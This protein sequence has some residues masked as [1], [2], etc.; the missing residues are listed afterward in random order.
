DGAP[1][2]SR[3]GRTGVGAYAFPEPRAGA[4]RVIG[5]P[6]VGGPR[7]SAALFRDG[8]MVRTLLADA[9]GVEGVWW[10]GLDDL[11]QPAPAGGYELKSVAHDARLIDDGSVGDSGN[12]AGVFHTDSA[13]RAVPLP[14]G[15]FVVVNEYE[16]T[17]ISIRRYAASGQP[18]YAAALAEADFAGFDGDGGD[19][20]ALLRPKEPAAST[21]VR[22]TLPG[23]RA[24][25]AN[26]ADAYPVFA[27]GEASQQVAGLAVHAGKAHVSLPA[28]GVVR[29][30]DL[31]SGG[32][33]HDWTLPGAGDLADDPAGT[34]WVLVGSEVVSL[35]AHGAVAKRIVTGLAAPLYLAAGKDRLAVIDQAN[36]RVAVIDSVKGTILATYGE[37]RGDGMWKPVDTR[38]W[39]HPRGAAF[40]ADGRLLVCEEFRIRAIWPETGAIAFEGVSNFMESFVLHPTQP[41]YGYC[42]SGIY[43]ID[44]KSGAWAMVVGTPP[45]HQTAEHLK[46]KAYGPSDATVI[47]GRPY[48]MYFGWGNR[49]IDISDPLEPRVVESLTGL[50]DQHL[51]QSNGYDQACFGKDGAIIRLGMFHMQQAQMW[52]CSG[53]DGHDPVYDFANPIAIGLPE[54]PSPRKLVAY[55]AVASDGSGDHVYELVDSALHHQKIAFWGAARTGVARIDPQ[56]GAVWHA[57]SSGDN[58]MALDAIRDGD[59]SFVFAAKYMDGFLDVFDGDGLRLTTGGWSYRSGF[60]GGM[61]DLRDGVSV[62]RL[63]DGTIVAY[64]EDDAFGRFGRFRFDGRESITRASARI[65]WQGG[66]VASDRVRVP[67]APA[68]AAVL[69]RQGEIPRVPEMKVDVDWLAW[70]RAGVTPQVAVLPANVSFKRILPDG[71]LD[72]FRAGTGVAAFAHDGAHLYA[73]FLVVDDTLRFDDPTGMAMYLYDSIE[74]WFEEEQFGVGFTKDGKPML[75]KYRFHNRAGEEYQMNLALPR[76]DVAGALLS[77]VGA[78]PLGA[79]L[80]S[81]TGTSFARRPGYVLMARIAYPDVKL[82]PGIAGRS[83]KVTDVTGAAGEILRLGVTIDGVT[84]WGTTQDFKVSWPGGMMFSDPNSLY[85]MALGR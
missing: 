6:A 41:D 33:L 19:L 76:D 83:A 72:D 30:V 84:A 14:D 8:R 47:G 4:W 68:S 65:E 81:I 61:V 13:L 62:A 73:Y 85:P 57:L 77:D 51:G 16:E 27:A 17:G 22:F 36:A 21:L 75:N 24:P 35:D 45:R 71:L 52:R 10:D 50:L 70:K 26:G 25:M 67:D 12:L 55:G 60:S 49:L 64:V 5:A 37:P 44:Q 23:Q 43:R 80:T 32:K 46:W 53:L 3:D 63:T 11:G 2:P 7:Q 38:T 34:L 66:G 56:N 74:L 82:A 42:A 1:L 28:A 39:D 78:H 59:Q 31:A 20:F 48:L 54:D 15:G 40:L 79:H 69:P 18:T 58:Y 9:C 29:V